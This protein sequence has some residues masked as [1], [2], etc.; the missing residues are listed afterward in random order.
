MFRSPHQTISSW[1]AAFL[2]A[3]LIPLL[4]IVILG[5]IGGFLKL[6]GEVRENE[7]RHFD[8]VILLAMRVPGNPADPVGSPR[9]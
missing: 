8:E 1:K 9:V 7:T 6:A 3:P 4:V 2:R 5:S